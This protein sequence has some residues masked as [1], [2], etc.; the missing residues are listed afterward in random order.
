MRCLRPRLPPGEEE[1][2]LSGLTSDSQVVAE[3]Q[4]LVHRNLFDSTEDK[5]LALSLLDRLKPPGERRARALPWPFE[6]TK[7]RLELFKRLSP[8]GVG[9]GRAPS[10][11]SFL[12]RSELSEDVFGVAAEDESGRRGVPTGR[13]RRRRRRRRQVRV[14][15][16]PAARLVPVATRMV[17]WGAGAAAA[18]SSWTPVP[19]PPPPKE[20]WVWADRSTQ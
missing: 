6:R 4:W 17:A 9:L 1:E 20:E 15:A 3:L 8:A 10:R 16:N 2:P 5:V 13:G 12:P 14:T 7:P 18:A 19:P 11:P